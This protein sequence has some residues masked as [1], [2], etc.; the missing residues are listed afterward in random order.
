MRPQQLF[1]STVA[2]VLVSL[3]GAIGQTIVW[4][5]GVLAQSVSDPIC[6]NVDTVVNE[7]A[8]LTP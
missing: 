4:R 2:T 8:A 6:V 5:Q 3:S 7:P 1:R